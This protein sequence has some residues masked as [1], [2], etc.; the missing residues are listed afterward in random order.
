MDKIF[1]ATPLTLCGGLKLPHQASLTYFSTRGGMKGRCS[2][3]LDMSV[4][5]G[6]P[7][8]DRKHSLSVPASLQHR[9]SLHGKGKEIHKLTTIPRLLG[10]HGC[11]SQSLEVEQQQTSQ[12]NTAE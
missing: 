10:V 1:T 2:H 9:K 3:P 8:G 12:G 4:V 6:Q 11:V 5:L 7:Q